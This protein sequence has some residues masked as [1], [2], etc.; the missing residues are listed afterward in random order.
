MILLEIGIGALQMLRYI[1][2]ISLTFIKKKNLIKKV[3]NYIKL[4][5]I[6]PDE[7]IIRETVACLTKVVIMWLIPLSL[8]EP[9]GCKHSSLKYKSVIV[10]SLF[11]TDLYNI[12]DLIKYWLFDDI[13]A[14]NNKTQEN[15][16]YNN[17]SCAAMHESS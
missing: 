1:T 9:D 14:N 7:Q 15:W 11:T 13:T 16:T 5:E 4:H 12:G 8:K 3:K 17:C 10:L 6:T 2:S